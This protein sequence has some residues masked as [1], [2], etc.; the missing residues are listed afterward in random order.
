MHEATKAWK[1]M[2]RLIQ[3]VSSPGIVYSIGEALGKTFQFSD[4]GSFNVFLA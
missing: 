4:I 1:T 3:E 2:L